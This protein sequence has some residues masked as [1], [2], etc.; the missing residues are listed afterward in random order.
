MKLAKTWE[1]FA[2]CDLE[3]RPFVPQDKL[4]PTL[5][6]AEESGERDLWKDC[7]LGGE[8][9][10]GEIC[11]L[12]ELG[13]CGG[14]EWQDVDVSA[15]GVGIFAVG[16]DVRAGEVEEHV[17]QAARAEEAF[18]CGI[19][20]MEAKCVARRSAGG[21]EDNLGAIFLAERA[22]GVGV[23]ISVEE[24]GE[25]GWG[26]VDWVPPVAVGIEDDCAGAEDLLDAVRVF[27]CDADDHVD[28]FCGTEGLADEWADADKLGV[29]FGVFDGDLGG[30]GHGDSLGKSGGR[31]KWGRG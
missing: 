7:E 19:R 5:P 20:A 16:G 12:D 6:G 28:E 2:A 14:V 11:G 9:A 13:D 21:L 3:R 17:P 23:G 24:G 4:K 8:S 22:G 1:A 27:S 15:M 29:V 26:G 10:R 25:F 18:A 31:G 30:E